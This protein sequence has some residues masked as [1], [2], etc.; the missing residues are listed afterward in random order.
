MIY[1]FRFELM[2]KCW[3]Y[4]PEGRPSFRYCL[5]YLVALKKKMSSFWDEA[6]QPSNDFE[7]ARRM[8]LKDI[9]FSKIQY[10]PLRSHRKGTLLLPTFK[11][12]MLY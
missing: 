6:V 3:S 12:T 11:M 7:L 2:S 10:H 4:D 1:L 9:V 5:D 8:E